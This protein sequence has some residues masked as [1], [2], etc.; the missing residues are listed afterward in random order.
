MSLKTTLRRNVNYVA[1]ICL[2]FLVL[3]HL[4]KIITPRKSAEN[5]GM[6]NEAI[7]YLLSEYKDLAAKKNILHKE[8][9]LEVKELRSSLKKATVDLKLKEE[10]CITDLR[11]LNGSVK[12][13]KKL[14]SD[15]QRHLDD[16][17]NMMD[18]NAMVLTAALEALR[19]A[20]L[21]VE[22]LERQLGL[23]GT[24]AVV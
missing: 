4:L 19:E 3:N 14:S 16:A 24:V 18:R 13:W 17:H 8:K 12:M 9:Y 15:I 22:R 1:V 2:S 23:N 10:Q 5:Y 6:C 21:K 11:G 7:E 20:E